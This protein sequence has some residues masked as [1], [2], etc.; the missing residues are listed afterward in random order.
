MVTGLTP[1][2]TYLFRVCVSTSKGQGAWSQAVSV[3]V[4]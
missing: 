3:I 4:H 2:T 1:L